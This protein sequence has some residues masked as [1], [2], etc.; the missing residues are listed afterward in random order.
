V[1]LFRRGDYDVAVFQT[2]KEVEVTV[3]KACNAKKA[4]YSDSDV[5]TAL[6][7]KAFRPETGPLADMT[8]VC[9][10]REA[11]M[12]LFSG[13]IGHAKNPTSH[14]DLAINAQEAARLIIFASHLLEFVEQRAEKPFS[15]VGVSMIIRDPK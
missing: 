1:P 3:R 10:E 7:R 9:A 13:A 8:V 11:V 14:R 2:F 15:A 5:C 6:M 4:G 12:R